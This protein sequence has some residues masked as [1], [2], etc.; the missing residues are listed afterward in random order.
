MLDMVM[1][2]VSASSDLSTSLSY[3]GR[4]GVGC[5]ACDNDS[6]QW[7]YEVLEV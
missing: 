7:G 4:Y 3:T 6:P 2:R 5:I 1:A